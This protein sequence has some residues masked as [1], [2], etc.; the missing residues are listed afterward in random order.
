MQAKKTMNTPDAQSDSEQIMQTGKDNPQNGVPAHE[1]A[2]ADM[3]EDEDLNN[4]AGVE[5]DLDEGE[6][7]RLEGEE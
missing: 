6:L 3:L 2:E 4:D 1:A 7:A 5:D